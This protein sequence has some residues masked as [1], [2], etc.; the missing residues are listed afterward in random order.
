[1]HRT[2]LNSSPAPRIARVEFSRL[3]AV[4]RAPQAFVRIA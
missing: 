4:Y 3:P 2:T 1:M